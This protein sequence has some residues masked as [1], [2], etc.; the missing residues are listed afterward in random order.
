MAKFEDEIREKGY[1]VYTNVGDSMMPL[2]RE[3]RDLI[4][5]SK[6]TEPLKKYD[7]VLYK[8]PTGAYV[9]HRIIKVCGDGQYLIS[10]DNRSNEEPVPEEWII[11]ILTEVIRDGRHISVESEEYK[12][13][14][15]KLKVRRFIKK[16]LAFPRTAAW[17]A[18]KCWEKI[19]F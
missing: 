4:V 17:K 10:G 14:L 18:K 16:L 11:G 13:Y 3:R 6:I 5:V 7:T 1:I 8:R 9:L 15:R 12:K 19:V 2:L